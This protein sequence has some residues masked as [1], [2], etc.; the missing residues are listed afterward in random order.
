MGAIIGQ[1][2]LVYPGTCFHLLENRP[3]LECAQNVLLL[4][5]T[6]SLDQ[7]WF[8]HGFAVCAIPEQS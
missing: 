3:M 1:W 7:S 6:A 4:L 8:E 2:K 5:S